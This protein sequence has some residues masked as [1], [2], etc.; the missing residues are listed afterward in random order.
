MPHSTG[1]KKF[2]KTPFPQVDLHRFL[3]DD[4]K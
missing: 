1:G 4:P 2:E 3:D